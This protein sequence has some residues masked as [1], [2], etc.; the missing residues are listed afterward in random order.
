MDRPANSLV[1]RLRE[2]RAKNTTLDEQTQA[3]AALLDSLLSGSEPR[4]RE[5][6]TE[7]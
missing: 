2:I 5:L 6:E 1:S 7:T 4:V 3:L